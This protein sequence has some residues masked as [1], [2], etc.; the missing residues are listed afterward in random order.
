MVFFIF[1]N[2][3]LLMK[4]KKAARKIK[5]DNIITV[6]KLENISTLSIK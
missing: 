3:E 6:N 5:R 1:Y 2:K 4:K